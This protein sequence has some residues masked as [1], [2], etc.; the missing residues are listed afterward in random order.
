M[1]SLKS[2]SILILLFTGTF[3]S[4]SQNTKSI[5]K[6][7][8]QIGAANTGSYINLLKGK[9][10]GVIVN[11]SSYINSTHL[12]DSLIT[13]GVDVKKVF[14]P[15]HGFRG[16]IDA[17]KKVK[18]YTDEKTGLPI[19]SLYGKNKKPS[20]EQLADIDIVI[21]DIQDVGVRFYTY[22]STMHYAMEACAENNKKMIVLDRPNPNAYYIDGPILDT[23]F[24]SFLG[25]HP[26][27]IVYGMTIGEYGQ[28]INGEKW[29]KDSVVCDLTVIALQKYDHNMV[30]KLPIQ[31]SPN[32]RNMSAIY[33]Y[34]SMGL[35]EGTI[36]SV[37]R[38]TDTPFQLIGHPELK[39]TTKNKK[40]K[41][42]TYTPVEKPGA[43]YPKFKN[44]ECKGINIADYGESYIK[45]SKKIYLNWVI[46][47][48]N[49][50]DDKASFFEANFDY[51]AG[52]DILQQ[53]IKDG[54][55][56]KE[57]HKTWKEGLDNFKLIREKYLIY[58]DFK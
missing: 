20:V 54:V 38:G 30:Y 52:N 48:Y 27:P 40:H 56:I 25:L 1:N 43:K 8:I 50:I 39:N 17:G 46:D 22:L 34:P 4:C 55:S 57:I 9:S 23:A 3:V 41:A 11:Q 47:A 16:A 19:I 18:S 58:P 49:N 13:L 7:V 10:V 12:I 15:E 6:P 14:C 51:H 42:L 37:G 32:L 26:V 35:F 21:F 2:I 33:M 24:S 29:L 44:K 36:I 5:P 31:P 45:N 53:Q 28:M